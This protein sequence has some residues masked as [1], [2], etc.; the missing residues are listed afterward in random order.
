[1][2]MYKHLDI[3]CYKSRHL[4]SQSLLDCKS[5][6]DIKVVATDNRMEDNAYLDVRT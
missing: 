5:T 4:S 3:K 6:T 2:L 1:L